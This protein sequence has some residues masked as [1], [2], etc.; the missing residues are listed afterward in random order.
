M[1]GENT[2][3]DSI[4]G[5][6][7]IIKKEAALLAAEIQSGVRGPAPP[8][9]SNN[10]N[11]N[12]AS[13]SSAASASP[14]KARAP[15]TPRKD[16]VVGGRVGKNGTP[17]KG[18]RG[19][20]VGVGV[21]AGAGAGSTGTDMDGHGKGVKEEAPSSES[22]MVEELNDAEVD[23]MTAGGSAGSS[24]YEGHGHGHGH[25]NGNGRAQMGG[26]FD[27]GAEDEE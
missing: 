7:R 16:A 4:E 12:N 24:V 26:F 11:N 27:V 20:G 25:R 8:R 3:Y 1:Y 21:G 5:R 10:N 13:F 6:F 9:A 17:T 22:S 23:W 18:R 19:V 15:R 14:R 2:T